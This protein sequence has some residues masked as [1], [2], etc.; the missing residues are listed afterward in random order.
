MK[1]TNMSACVKSITDESFDAEVLS[2]QGP[3]LVDFYTPT[4]GPCKMLAPT[5]EQVCETRSGRLKVVKIDASENLQSGVRF[6]L[7]VVPTLL[8]F[9]DGQTIGMRTGLLSRQQIDQ[10]IETVIAA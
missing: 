4:C 8:L 7:Q 10:W 1:G 2:H 5:L 6:R 3:V 9:R